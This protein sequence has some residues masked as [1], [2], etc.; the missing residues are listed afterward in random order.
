[1]ADT[2]QDQAQGPSAQPELTNTLFPPPPAYYK[3]FT[4]ANLARQTASA[5]P[6]GT[7]KQRGDGVSAAQADGTDVGG[8]IMGEAE[9]D[10]LRKLSAV[11]D[12]PNVDWVVQEG[13]WKCFGETYT[14]S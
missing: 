3:A 9:I 1:M 11:L 2:P 12:P 8:E 13:R 10:E 5:G 14:V 4:A 6:S 7:S